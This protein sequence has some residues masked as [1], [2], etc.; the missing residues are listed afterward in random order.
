MKRGF[1]TTHLKQKDR[2]LSKQQLVKAVQSG[3]KLNSGLARL[4]GIQIGTEAAPSGRAI[5]FTGGELCDYTFGYAAFPLWVGRC[6]FF[7]E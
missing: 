5:A 2:Q 1:T 7:G 6:P 3:Q 4:H